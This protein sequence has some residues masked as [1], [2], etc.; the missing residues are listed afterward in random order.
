[1]PRLLVAVSLLLALHVDAKP[2]L[3]VLFVGNSLTFAN[4]LP[5]TFRH[6]AKENDVQ[7]E[8]VMIAR[9]DFALEDH[10]RGNLR[11]VLRRQRWDY[12]VVQQGPS[13]MDDSRAQLIRDTKAI[14]ALLQ[15]PSRVAVLMVWPPR[16][17]WNAMDRVA[18]SHRLAAEA[19]NGVL[20]PAGLLLH[21]ELERNPRAALFQ[22]DGFHPTPLA[23]ELMARALWESLRGPDW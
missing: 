7:V 10:L 14:A 2:R 16:S 18:E 3:R 19:V 23:T 12:I 1:V 21:A 15:P 8:T 6:I 17:R 22:D 11:D 4:D 20:V 5:A 9:P 13:S